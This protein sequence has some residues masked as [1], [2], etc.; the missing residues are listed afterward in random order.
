MADPEFDKPPAPLLFTSHSGEIFELKPDELPSTSSLYA[1]SVPSEMED[2]TGV[3]EK[4]DSLRVSVVGDLHN[5]ESLMTSTSL[6][7]N[8]SP[9]NTHID[10]KVSNVTLPSPLGTINESTED[11][12]LEVPPLKTVLTPPTPF[13]ASEGKIT[14]DI[15]DPSITKAW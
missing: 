9:P 7:G 15:T 2:I 1:S 4:M 12:V 6:D 10:N 14:S 5:L 13:V 3:T 8:I 11:V